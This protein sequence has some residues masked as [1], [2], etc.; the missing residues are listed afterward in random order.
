MCFLWFFQTYGSRCYY[1]K[2]SLNFLSPF[3]SKRLGVLAGEG[4]NF[5]RTEQALRSLI[6]MPP[7]HENLCRNIATLIQICASI[8]SLKRAR[9]IHALVLTTNHIPI[10]AQS[11]YMYNNVLSMYGRCGSIRDARQV[12]DEM[13]KRSLVSY[14]AL[15]AA[16]SRDHDHAHLTFRLID[17]MEFEC[18]RPNGLTFTSLAQAVSLLEDQLMGSLL[19]AQVIK[20]GSS[21]DT[22]VQT[23]LLGMYSNC[24]DFESAK[25]I[26][27]LIGDKD[28][29][30]W[31][32]IILGNFKNEKMKE[33]LSLFGAMVGSGV[34][35]TQ[36][37]YSM[38]LNACS[39]MGNFVCGKVI[40]ARVIIS[41]IQVDL[42]LENALL[43]MYSKCSDTQTAFS[44]FTRIENPDLV[45][46]NSMIAGYME[47]GNGEKAMDM[48]VAL[49]RLSLPKPDE[50]TFAAIISAT[51]ALPASAYGKP[52]HALVIKTG[53]DSS[54][55]VG[56][57]LLNMYFKNGDAESPQKVFMLIAEKDIVLWTEMIIGHSR[58]GDGECAI[59]LFCKMCRE[60]HKCDTF[61]LS[62]ALSACADLAILKQ[63]EMIHSQ[64]EKTGHGVEMS[65][66]GSLV[67]M[68]AK[69]GDLRAAESIFSQVLH[70][71]LKCWNA[72]L[73][74]YSHYGMA[75]EAF[76][77]FEVI[78]EHG[79]RPDEIT[80]LS[81]LSACSHSGLVERGKILWN[82][83]KEHSLI[84]GHKH[85]SCMVS[86]LS[87][88]GLL[89][90]AEN[91]IAESPYSEIRIEL[92]RT[93]LSTCVAKRNSRM[94]IQAAEQV[95]RLDP[96]DG[97]THI[98]LSNLYAATGRW[99]CVAKMRRKMKGSMLGK[100]PGLS[101]I[102][103]KNNVHVFSSGDQSHPKIDDAQAELHRLRGNMRKL[104]TDE[105]GKEVI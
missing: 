12:F 2:I 20:Y 83:M 78:L 16:Y 7:T 97:T 49:R 27:G 33:G 77:V 93:L 60:G 41:S 35:P 26:F 55:F 5:Q 29:V 3:K 61:A 56:T 91:L 21:E 38:L 19:H 102:E 84:P 62:G 86:L 100:E 95:L 105:F 53:Y 14:N 11:P 63:G 74:G 24:G 47:N 22:C 85:Y 48:F 69:N 75:E 59:K 13:P 10:N 1:P 79:L 40:H 44:V 88:A 18:L 96:E 54:V 43:D 99:D 32:S 92:W 39:R 30:A 4:F 45:S 67:D 72:L 80:F 36:F 42:P 66:C 34:N 104:V 64:A 87:R 8:T 82:Q 103:A 46:W 25:R 57:T 6:F 65:V 51:S 76:V 9:Q 15:I 98:L 73:G 31:N 89:D 101:W 17:Q 37:T 50:Y 52:L 81:L 28:A 23:S 94:V 68:Y 90:E 58:M 71:D 70:P